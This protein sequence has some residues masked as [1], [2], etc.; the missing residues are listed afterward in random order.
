MEVIITN[1]SGQAIGFS[2]LKDVI[3]GLPVQIATAG[4][5]TISDK[6][7]PEDIFESDSLRQ[8]FEE[9]DISMTIDA[10]PV[11]TWDQLAPSSG[12]VSVSG[13]T[14]T[15]ITNDVGVKPSLDDSE[16]VGL[17]ATY[18]DVSTNS[19]RKMNIINYHTTDVFITF[20]ADAGNAHPLQIPRATFDG[21][22]DITSVSSIEINVSGDTK[23]KAK[24][25][26][27]AGSIAV[28]RTVQV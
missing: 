16:L 2:D 8:A 11:T 20:E 15:G 5:L 1:I 3:S 23:I 17:T 19:A 25:R 12:T 13:G 24:T 6:F 28:V 14:I 7:T 4:T 9:G 21:A 18:A 22:G 10:V 26:T 27:G